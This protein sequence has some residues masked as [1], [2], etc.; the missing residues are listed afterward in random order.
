MNGG[1]P[2][3]GLGDEIREHVERETQENIER[4]MKPADARSAALRKFGNVAS[5]MEDT[6]DV[7]R[8]VWLEQLL[9]DLGY[10]FRFVRSNP[11]FTAVVVLTL[12]LGIGMN[13][14]VFSVVNTVLLKPLSY[15]NPERLVWLGEY[16]PRIQREFVLRRDFEVW[17]KEL[18]SYSGLAGF[19]YQQAALATPSGSSQVTTVYA[20][21]DFWR[22]TGAHPAIG[23]LF[24][25]SEPDSLVLT[26]PL[27]QQEFGGDPQIVGKTVMLNG[28]ATQITGV[29]PE[30]FVFQF[31]MWWTSIHPEP[32]RGFIAYPRLS[33][34]MGHGLQV[35]GALKPGITAAEAEAELRAAQTRI[36]E[37]TGRRPPTLGL[38]VQSLREKLAG[39]T[40]QALAVL[41]AAG[42]FLLLI[43]CVNVAN[44]L[45]AR[46]TI[47][48][49]EI[50]IRAA[51][52]AGRA[53]VIRQLL[54]ESV[55]QSF[56]GG[57]AGLALAWCA[58]RMVVGISPYAIPRLSETTIDGSVL[59]FT[60]AASLI[61]GVLFGSGPAI[62]LW[63][64]NLS[65]ALRDGMRTTSGLAGL[66]T[67]R[68]LVAVQL[69]VAIIL[70]TGAGLMLKSYSMMNEHAPGLVPEKVVVLKM[71]FAGQ[72]Y[73]AQPA[74]QAYLK[75]VQRRIE[76][77]PGI[78]AAGLSSWFFFSGARAFPADKDQTQTRVVRINVASSGY[79][80]ALGMRL[81]RGRWLSDRDSGFAL[82]NESMARLAFGSIDPI[83]R[84]LS[85]PGS[86]T[87][88]G[89]LSDVRYFK[90]DE[91]AAPEVFLRHSPVPLLYGAE[92][93][94][95][96][97]GD[98]AAAASM[99]NKLVTDVDASQPVY[100]ATSLDRA[101][102]E[103]I[104]P[105]R[106]NLFLLM[107]LAASSL[108]LAL[109]GIYGLITYSVA[110]RTREIGVRM[111]LGAQRTQV[112]ALVVREALPLAII[113]IVAG[114]SAALGLTRLMQGLLYAVEA[115]DPSIFVTAGILLGVA[116]IAA[117][118]G[119]A[120]KAASIDPTTALRSE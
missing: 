97:S 99:L 12:A 119:P 7:W 105:R 83:G 8:L 30:S 14:S 22:I 38:R 113:G 21:G 1:D 101:L 110:E 79:M 111:A 15:P 13:T 63:R 37:A 64:T 24:E 88:A 58:I 104:A 84:Q 10:A 66:R 90:L 42:A 81:V 68:L 112:A 36:Q 92:I 60:F 93:A 62:S 56:A 4:G 96:T 11:R 109:I 65:N 9:Q 71:R 34:T 29:L 52:G 41:L 19:G 115:S 59:A 72:Q 73:K 98:A 43:A 86:V 44:L 103:S 50:S 35:V 45:L 32:V 107:S 87:I 47:R 114:L 3:E 46:S 16:D 33:E 82:L 89:I 28:R 55:L 20:D 95:R 76:G 102:A 51:L 53:R 23:R 100:G 69:S 2:L 5:V 67:R 106:F 6:R 40:R 75:E 54:A 117:C 17:R 70:L 94:A 31:P 78:E 116:A 108:L 74:Q 49:R 25:G 39:G 80:E 26:W 57:V 85:I 120:L 18:R 118:I 48:R 91:D 27:F 77:A 61:T